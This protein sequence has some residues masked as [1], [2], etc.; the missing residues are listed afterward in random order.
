MARVEPRVPGAVAASKGWCL[1]KK[2]TEFDRFRTISDDF[3]TLFDMFR[4]VVDQ[5][6][7]IGQGLVHGAPPPAH[8]GAS[9]TALQQVEHGHMAKLQMEFKE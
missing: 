4:P 8:Q 1:R 6:A 9:T 7:G 3:S 2:R 5:V